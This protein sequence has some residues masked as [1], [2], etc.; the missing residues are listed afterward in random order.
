MAI[1]ISPARLKE[2]Q[3]WLENPPK[4]QCTICGLYKP[5]T[6]FYGGKRKCK[7]CFNAK[8]KQYRKEHSDDRRKQQRIYY[9]THRQERREWQHE[10]DTN[11]QGA[12]RA[13]NAQYQQE[14]HNERLEYN[15]KNL[16]KQNALYLARK[17]HFEIIEEVDPY[18]VYLRDLGHCQVCMQPVDLRIKQPQ[19]MA[20]TL[21]HTAPV[22]SYATVRLTHRI[23]NIVIGSPIAGRIAYVR[24]ASI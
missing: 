24:S 9:Q 4:K 20:A 21:D 7:V 1:K 14:H 15:R 2:I 22:H 17:R 5:V 13:Y 18:V 8:H 6:E 11:H 12:K 3:A 10:Y 19:L 23:C 16:W